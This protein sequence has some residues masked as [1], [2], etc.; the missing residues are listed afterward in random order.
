MS[1]DLTVT[2]SLGERDAQQAS[3]STFRLEE[4]AKHK[5]ADDLWLLIHGKVHSLLAGDTNTR[6]R[7]VT[8]WVS[9]GLRCVRLVG[10]PGRQRGAHQRRRF[11][12]LFFST[13]WFCFC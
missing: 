4:I 6:D 13:W 10:A 12:K 1:L 5:T 11:V 3:R 7:N 9:I 2:Y 8:S